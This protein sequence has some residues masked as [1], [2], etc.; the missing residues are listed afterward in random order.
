MD[1]LFFLLAKAVISIAVSALVLLALSQPLLRVLARICPD[2][3]AALFWASY[4]K[5][6]LIVAPLLLVLL[7][8]LV[9]QLASPFEGLRLA[10][11]AALAGVLL[12]MRAIGKRVGLFVRLP[13]SQPRP[14]SVRSTA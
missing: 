7:L 1:A 4:T 2:Q 10:L 5:V 13:D 6:M 11:L 12:G 14:A 3:D 9:L 8:D